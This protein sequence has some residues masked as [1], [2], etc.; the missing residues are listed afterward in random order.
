MIV[1]TDTID[2]RLENWLNIHKPDKVV[3]VASEPS[4]KLCLPHLSI[5]KKLDN[6][7]YRLPDGDDAKTIDYC[8]DFWS[9]MMRNDVTRKSVIIAIGGGAVLDFAG[10]CASVFMRGIPCVYVP[11]TLLSMVDGSEGGKTGINFYGT[12]NIIGTFTEP[13]AILR[14]VD[15]L[16]TLT[17]TEILSGWAE[18]V[19]HGILE[20]GE[21][22]RQIQG[23]IKPFSDEDYW[24]NLI[25]LNIEFKKSITSSDFKEK[26]QRKLLNLGHTIGHGLEALYFEDTNITHGKAVANGIYWETILAHELGLTSEE[27]LRTIENLIFP[28]YPK[29]GWNKFQV[30]EIGNLLLHDKKNENG[31]IHFTFSKKIGSA[32]YNVE[33]AKQRI[34]D[35]LDKYAEDVESVEDIL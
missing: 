13:S 19:K 23:G 30:E 35:F 7:I 25:R 9:V 16:P 2:S 24:M 6:I 29:I 34:C 4:F 11:T 33:V 27:N 28:L 10:F 15:F 5:H 32:E 17:K 18:I 12:K 1:K 3:V 8:Q 22:Y 20:G 26:G 21:I 31:W 14:N